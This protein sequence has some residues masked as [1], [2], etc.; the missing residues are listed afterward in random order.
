MPQPTT[1]ILSTVTV[2]SPTGLRLFYTGPNA[3]PQGTA[4]NVT[5]NALYESSQPYPYAIDVR[6]GNTGWSSMATRG[7]GRYTATLPLIASKGQQT[8][9]LNVHFGNIITPYALGTM[10]VQ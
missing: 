7:D 10:I 2:Q 6:I 3:A 9:S 5:V 8:V 4:I 1:V